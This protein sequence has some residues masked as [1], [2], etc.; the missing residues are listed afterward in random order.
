M[1]IGLN[2]HTLSPSLAQAQA[3]NFCLNSA[4]NEVIPIEMPG[5]ILMS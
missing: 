1:L 5:V 2:T 4:Q 3:I